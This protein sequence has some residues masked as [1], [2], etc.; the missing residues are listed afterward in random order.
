LKNLSPAAWSA[1]MPDG[2][3]RHIEPGRSIQ[4]VAG[5]RLHF[6]PLEGEIRRPAPQPVPASK[7][8]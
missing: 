1:T 4:L 7:V 5:V 8:P 2:S 6:G 3:A